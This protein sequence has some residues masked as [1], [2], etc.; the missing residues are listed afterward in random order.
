MSKENLPKRLMKKQKQ[1]KKR[2]YTSR[3]FVL[4]PWGNDLPGL[5]VEKLISRKESWRFST[6]LGPKKVKWKKIIV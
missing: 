5:T 3:G 2:G 1:A 6:N 4:W